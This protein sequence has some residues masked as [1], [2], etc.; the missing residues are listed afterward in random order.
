MSPLSTRGIG[1][2]FQLYIKLRH[3]INV[4]KPKQI[5]AM[6]V[7]EQILLPQPKK[8]KQLQIHNGYQGGICVLSAQNIATSVATLELC[9]LSLWYESSLL[10]LASFDDSL[11]RQEFAQ[12]LCAI[13]CRV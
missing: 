4:L 9:K 7:F 8:P 1:L 3:S 6:L 12:I 13:L 11:G 10:P 2:V 5:F